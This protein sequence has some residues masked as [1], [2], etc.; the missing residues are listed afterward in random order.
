MSYMHPSPL[1]FPDWST[2][3]RASTL[4]Q[5]STVGG[6]IPA[7]GAHRIASHPPSKLVYDDEGR[8]YT[9]DEHHHRYPLEKTLGELADVADIMGWMGEVGVT[10]LPL[11]LSFMFTDLMIVSCSRIARFLSPTPC[12][13]QASPTGLV[14]LCPT[15]RHMGES[16]ALRPAGQ[17]PAWLAT[18][19]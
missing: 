9:L 7:T 3:G 10:P 15:R 1:P 14:F 16:A 12:T 8:H 4:L 19:P 11:P 2:G 13:P 17:V 18:H 5:H 6:L